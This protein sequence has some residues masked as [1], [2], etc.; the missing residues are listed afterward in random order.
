MVDDGELVR[1]VLRG[2]REAFGVLVERYKALAVVRAFRRV[3]RASDA[4]DIAQDAFVRAFVS[5]KNLRDPDKFRSWLLAIVANRARDWYRRKRES[6]G[7]DVENQAE[8]RPASRE[9]EL[10]MAV[11]EAIESLP[12]NYQVVAAMRYLEGLRYSEMSSKLGLSEVAL[13]K[14]IHRANQ[15][16]RETLKGLI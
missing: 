3:R 8:R 10:R 11:V 12:E 6:P 16:L 13:R 4:E 14:R 1:K 7:L 2:D 5:L 9:N 15:L